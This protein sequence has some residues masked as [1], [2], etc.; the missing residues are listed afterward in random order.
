MNHIPIFQLIRNRG[1]LK[2]VKVMIVL[3]H[4]C[5]KKMRV[6]EAALPKGQTVKVRCPHCSAI[7]FMPDVVLLTKGST[8]SRSQRASDHLSLLPLEP[9]RET[10]TEPPTSPHPI[11][12][13]DFRLPGEQE[14]PTLKQKESVTRKRRFLVWG[15]VSLA[16][17]LA[18]ALLVNIM[19]PGPTGRKYFIHQNADRETAGQ[20]TKQSHP[21]NSR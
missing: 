7:G 6:D 17:V 8:S 20:S 13:R 21:K 14:T 15:L 19:L 16:V 12:S 3:C 11:V 1:F 9:L 18:F 2:A 4:Q 10:V 5:Q